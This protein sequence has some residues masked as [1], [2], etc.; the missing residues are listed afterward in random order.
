[1]KLQNY[2]LNKLALPEKKVYTRIC[3]ECRINTCAMCAELEEIMKKV[4]KKSAVVTLAGVLS[5]GMLAGCGN[6]SDELDGTK[7]VATVDGEEIPLG[8]LSFTVRYQQAY[9]EAMYE[10]Y[11]LTEY[12]TSIWDGAASDDTYDTYGEEIR[13]EVLS[14]IELMYL[15]RD[16]GADYGVEITDDDRAQIEEAAAAFMEANSEETLT[17]LG[18]TEE[19]IQTYLELQTYQSR[20]YDPII[21]DVDTE[22]SDEQ[23]QMSS[24]KYIHVS[25][26]ASSTSDEITEAEETA[27]AVYAALQEDPTG[28]MSEIVESVDDS[29]SVASGTF[30]TN[31]SDD[32]DDDTSTYYNEDMIAALRELEEGEMTELLTTDDGY[33][34]ARLEEAYDED[35]TESERDN[36]LSTRKS[37]LYSE[38]TEGWL[39]EAEI[40]VDEDV[41][42]KLTVTDAQEFTLQSTSG[43]TVTEETPE[44]G[45]TAE[46]GQTEEDGQTAE[47]GEDEVLEAAED[48]DEELEP[49]EE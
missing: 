42:A 25:A 3:V 9:L 2:F 35:A 1:V 7:T 36:I 20:I 29:L 17:T 39:D 30:Q 13:A 38:V 41:L 49:A 32:W 12:V 14:Q 27:N 10:A 15:M 34:I 46:D 22:I 33:Y 31:L 16:H 24:F 8:L 18:V 40:T 44:D 21:A 26:D 6:S 11:G 5:V 28:D 43:E 47:D 19:Q 45:Q 48:L 4:L 23:A 37:D